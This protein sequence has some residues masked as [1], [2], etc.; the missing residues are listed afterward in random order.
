MHNQIKLPPA[1]GETH[2]AIRGIHTKRL[3]SLQMHDVT[4]N[5]LLFKRNETG[6]LPPPPLGYS[7]GHGVLPIPGK[8]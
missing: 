2:G 5:N 8:K 4:K 1:R 3:K 6:T 7:K